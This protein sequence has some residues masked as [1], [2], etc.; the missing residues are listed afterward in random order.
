MTDTPFAKPVGYSEEALFRARAEKVTFVNPKGYELF[1]CV[2][3]QRPD[4]GD[5]RSERRKRWSLNGDNLARQ[6][7]PV[8]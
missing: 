7:R 8:K 6:G 2:N 4:P 1:N 5:E 3:G